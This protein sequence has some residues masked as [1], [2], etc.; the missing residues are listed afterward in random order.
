M[1]K[2]E[3]LQE[4]E[5]D[6]PKEKEFDFD[7]FECK[8]IADV[9]EWNRHA[10]K[11]HRKARMLDKH[12]QPPVPIKVPTGDMYPQAVVKFQRFDQ[13]ENIL[14]MR[15]RN[16]DIDWKGQ[17]KPGRK[18]TLPVP[19]I[20]FLNDLAY[21]IYGEVDVSHEGGETIKETRIVG[22]KNR[23]SCQVQF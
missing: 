22:E 18:Y 7:T 11:V 19:V 10:R 16:K 13:P 21:P 14:K 2:A 9:E 1:K 3:V 20:K 5:K 17:L 15:V 8:T 12:A 23:F 6:L 4:I